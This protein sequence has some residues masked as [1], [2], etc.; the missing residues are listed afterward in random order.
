MF[1]GLVFGFMH[2]TYFLS[3]DIGTCHQLYYLN[4]ITGIILVIAINPGGSVN[5]G[6]LDRFGMSQN[7]SMVDAMMDLVR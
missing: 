3:G 6:D 1:V 2:R 5:A 7:V 4:V